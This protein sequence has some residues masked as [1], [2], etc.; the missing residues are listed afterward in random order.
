MERRHTIWHKSQLNSNICNS[1][2]I[3]VTIVIIIIGIG[4]VTLSRSMDD[5]KSILC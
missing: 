5:T 4:I 1:N 3:V 2:Q